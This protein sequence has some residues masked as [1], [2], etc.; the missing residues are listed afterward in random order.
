MVVAA[1]R[2]LRSTRLRMLRCREAIIFR[3]DQDEPECPVRAVASAALAAHTPLGAAL[4]RP[5][6]A[7]AE[8]IALASYGRG[9]LS[10]STGK[11]TVF[12]TTAVSL[13]L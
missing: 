8:R 9:T 11:V 5:E 6:A 7:S 3:V 13:R 2:E 10:L 4:C 12:P 1:P